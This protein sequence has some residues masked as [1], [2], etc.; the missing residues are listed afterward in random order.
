M[1]E[2]EYREYPAI[3]Y[4]TLSKLTTS[5]VGLDE[6]QGPTSYFTMGSLVD[7]LCTDFDNYNNKYYISTV[8]PPSDAMVAYCKALASTGNA[9]TAWKAS[10]LK[11]DPTIVAKSSKDGLSKY[12]KEGKAY[13]ADLLRGKDKQVI[14]FDENATANRLA[15]ILKDNEFTGKY[16]SEGNTFQTAIIWKYYGQECKSLL[17]IIHIDHDKRTI[18]PVDLKTTGKSVFSF[19]KSY[20]DYK[21]YLQA[22]FYTA[23][24]EYAIKNDASFAEVSDYTV[25]PFQFIV[26]ETNYK[27]PPHIFEVSDTDLHVGEMGGKTS[28]GYDVKGFR[29]LIEDLNYH[30]DT[31]QWE[32]RPEIY[33]ED[34][35]LQ[36]EN[37][38]RQDDF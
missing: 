38:V 33:A 27:N 4:S 34:G 11:T 7:T 17:D 23:A 21:Y 16:F 8:T 30:K 1:T 20:M 14:S 10:G 5:P 19:Y 9:D 28:M 32:Y 36:L 31:N 37:L 18:R 2:Q 3:N 22:A 24:L 13:Y 15:N 26:I 35:I 29:T 6:Q 25:L 12:D